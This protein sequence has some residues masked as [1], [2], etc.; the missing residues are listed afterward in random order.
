MDP[1]SKLFPLN[2][3]NCLKKEKLIVTFLDILNTNIFMLT[4]KCP[5]C[6]KDFNTLF[7]YMWFIRIKILLDECLKILDFHS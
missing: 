7:S 1:K 6:S 2:C 5:Y 4:Y 3:I